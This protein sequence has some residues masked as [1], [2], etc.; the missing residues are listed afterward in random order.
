MKGKNILLGISGGIAAFKAASL[1][2]QLTKKG[3]NVQVIM[4]ESA[5]KFITPLTLQTLSRNHVFIDTFDEKDPKG[6]SH[7]DLADNADLSVVAPATANVIGKLAHGI[8]DDMLTTTLLAVTSP[9][10]I[11]PAMNVHMYQH[12]AVEENMRILRARGIRFIEPEEGLLACGYVGK[13]RL[14]EPEFIVEKLEEFLNQKQDLKGKKFLITAGATREKIDPIRYFTN[15]STGKMGYA[16][17]EAVLE[18]GGEVI[19]ISGKSNLLPPAGAHFISVESAEEMYLAVM[20]QLNQAD[21]IIKTAAV[22]DYRPKEVYPHKFKKKEGSWVI[23][24]ERTKD[25]ALEVGERKRNDQFFVGF[26]AE[27]EDLLEQ[28]KGKLLKK[29]MDMI[30]ANHILMEGA[31]FEQDT[32]VVTVITKKGEQ[33]NFPK[34]SKKELAHHILTEINKRIVGE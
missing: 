30:V 12:P 6:V 11:A 31:G 23:E 24:M 5:T 17:A 2:S 3:A 14:A 9:I 18:R 4:T 10:F 29:N 25:I 15:R 21:V 16:L 1:V 13:G 7:I 34:L 27:S 22:A 26:A 28:A 19:L 33:I 20:N 32:N 8:A